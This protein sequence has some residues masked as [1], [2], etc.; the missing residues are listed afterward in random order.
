M[1]FYEVLEQVLALLQ[2][3]AGQ[4]ALERSVTL[5]AVAHL[6]QGLAVLG[7][8]PDTPRVPSRNWACRSPWAQR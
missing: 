7:T 1:T 3:Q 6:T 4:R 5:E 2:Q 8:L